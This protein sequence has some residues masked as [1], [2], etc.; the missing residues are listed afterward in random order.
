MYHK[1][2][3][4]GRILK[5]RGLFVMMERF[6]GTVKWFDKKKG[7]GFITSDNGG[8]DLFVHYSSINSKGFKVLNEG[9]RV[10]FEVEKADKGEKAVNVTVI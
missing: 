4:K 9:D 2:L 5:K 1:A 8:S 10:E 7:F 3:S 6:K